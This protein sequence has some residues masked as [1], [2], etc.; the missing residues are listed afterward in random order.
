MITVEKGDGRIVVKFPYNKDYIEKIKS[1]N[2]YKWNVQEKYWYFPDND[3]VVNKILSVF[4]G[5]DITIDPALQ[6]FHVLERELV[7]RKYSPKTVKSYLHYNRELVKFTGKS[8]NEINESDIKDYLFYM[9]EKKDASASTLNTA[10]NALNFY[11]GKILK[12]N[13]V[14]EIKRPKKDKKLPVVLSQEEVTL[15]LSSVSNIKHKAILMLVYSAGLRVSEVVKLNVEDID[16][17]R[18]LIHLKGA[19]GRKDRYTILSDK[20]LETLNLYIKSYQPDRWLF[21]GAKK[22]SHLST[23][24]AQKIFDNAVKSAGIKKD[25][26]IHAL[27]HSFATHLL[28]EGIDLRYIQ[29]LLG[30]KNSKTTE[31]YTHVSTKSLGKI[32]SP[33]DNLKL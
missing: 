26:S 2:G 5:E 7:S 28:E 27:R 3:G 19:K 15:I 31:I 25:V 11:Y 20:V 21:T 4:L 6:E 9:V 23:R 32:R 17:D 1:I 13:F 24:S 22:T 29:E 10:V 18:K 14:Y 8:S 12:K 30:H 16:S 33:L